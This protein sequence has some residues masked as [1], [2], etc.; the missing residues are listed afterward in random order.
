LS[1]TASCRLDSKLASS[2]SRTFGS[3]G[4]LLEQRSFLTVKI[5]MAKTDTMERTKS[6]TLTLDISSAAVKLKSMGIMW[7]SVEAVGTKLG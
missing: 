4:A 3:G 1:S 2:Q 7:P 5:E 6:A